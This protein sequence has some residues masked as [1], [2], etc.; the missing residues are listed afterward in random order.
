MNHFYGRNLKKFKLAAGFS[1]SKHR[2]NVDSIILI[3]QSFFDGHA[4]RFKV[5]CLQNWSFKFCVSYCD[6][7]FDIIKGANIINDIFILG[8]L[9]LGKAVE[10]S[11]KN[12]SS[13]S[14]SRQING[15]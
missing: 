4:S 9:L 13:I 15:W 11:T 2:L 12:F 5:E 3:L 14:K 7:G 8:F 10:I 1:R 6:L